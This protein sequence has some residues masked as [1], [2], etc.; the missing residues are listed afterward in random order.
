MYKHYAN[1]E[2]ANLY[3]TTLANL[4]ALIKEHIDNNDYAD[5][6]T[7]CVE[8]FGDELTDYAADIAI[9]NKIEVTKNA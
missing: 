2:L 8:F 9:N 6:Y 4:A 5:F 7:N 1:K 3:V